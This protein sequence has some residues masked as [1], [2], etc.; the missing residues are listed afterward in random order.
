MPE[1]TT[2]IVIWM[3]PTFLFSLTE[4]SI[5]YRIKSANPALYREILGDQQHSWI[6]KNGWYLP[7]HAP[8]SFRLYRAVIERRDPNL[9]SGIVRLVYLISAFFSVAFLVCFVVSGV[10]SLYAVVSR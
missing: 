9:V 2:F 8:I 4:R 10:V 7:S 1:P 3:V 6:E 5:M